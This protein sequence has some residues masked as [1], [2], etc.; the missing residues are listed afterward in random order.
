MDRARRRRRVRGVGP[1]DRSFEQQFNVPGTRGLRD[2]S[3]SPRSTATAATSLRSCRSSRCQGRPSTRPASVR[4]RGGTAKVRPRCRSRGPPPMPRR[5]DRAF[6]SDDGR[7]TFALVY[8]P[9]AG[10]VDP[11]QEEARAAQ[12]ALDGVTVG[13]SPVAGDRA[14]CAA[15]RPATTQGRRHRAS[16]LEDPAGRAGRAAGPRL[17]LPLV[18][19]VRAAAD[20]ARRD[21][22]DLPAVWPLASVTDVSVIVQFLVGLIGLAIAIDYALLV[23]VRWREERQQPDVTNDDGGAERDA[24]RRLGRRLQRHDRGDLAARA[25]RP[26]VPFLRSIGIAGHADPAGQ[27]RRRDHAAAGRPRDHRA[28]GSTGRA[29]AATPTQ[30]RLVRLGAPRRAPPLDRRHPLDRRPGR[31]GSRRLDDPARQPAG[32]LAGPGRARTRRPRSLESSGIGTGPLSPFDALVRSG[33]PD[34][35]AHRSPGRGCPR[36]RRPRRLASRRDGAHRRHPDRGRQLAR[37]A[38]RRST[39]SAPTTRRAKSRSV[40]RRRRAPTSSTRSTATSR[41]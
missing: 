24:A 4:T 6:V 8:I 33:D 32:R 3:S 5:D 10:G 23:V 1:A 38:A 22:D 27:R 16:L 35:V 40:A 41:S 25:R 30:P 31:A 7:T 15:R 36:R 18:H 17:R 20:G 29:T 9:A 2:N 39:A 21:P 26:P 34:A 12:A 13:G 28:D 37:P 19:G 11:G 14:R